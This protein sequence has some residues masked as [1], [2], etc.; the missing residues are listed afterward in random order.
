M[1]LSVGGRTAVALISDWLKRM[2]NTEKDKFTKDETNCFGCETHEIFT[3]DE[4]N[5]FGCETHE[6]KR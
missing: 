1:K 2:L 4:T 6:I 3:K 5:C